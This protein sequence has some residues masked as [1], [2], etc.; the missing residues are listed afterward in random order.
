MKIVIISLYARTPLEST[1]SSRHYSIADSL[2]KLGHD[3][4]I[5][6]GSFD[7]RKEIQLLNN[8]LDFDKFNC[9]R[10]KFFR[11]RLPVRKKNLWGMIKHSFD[12]FFQLKKY[13]RYIVQDKP[14]IVIGC[15][16]HAV[17]SFQ[18]SLLSKKYKITFISEV[19][20]IWPLILRVKSDFYIFHPFYW[21]LK[22]MELWTYK[23]SSAIIHIASHFKRYLRQ[24]LIKK[25]T[26]F[27][28]NGIDL[29]FTS[30]SLVYRKKR[31]DSDFVVYY[32]GSIGPLNSI[33]VM[34]KA[35]EYVNQNNNNRPITFKFIGDGSLKLHYRDLVKA[36]G[37]SN[38]FFEDAI[39][40]KGIY[41]K[42]SEASLFWANLRPSC[43]YSYGV[44]MTK[45]PD[46]M[47]VGR[48]VVL[49]ANIPYS[50]ISD[51]NCGILVKSND[52]EA[53]GDSIISYS[54]L[55]NEE[56]DEIGENG[57]KWIVDNY[58]FDKLV[59]PLNEFI[60]SIDVN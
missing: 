47:Y 1:T 7:Q 51:A 38:V 25:P 13:F 29:N 3:V 6:C 46:Y 57:K 18:S 50:P 33:D 12:I 20:D 14:D 39:P 48:P 56:L 31:T 34:I 59:L 17:C 41:D 23:N 5:Y 37:L 19:R 9:G 27:L 58:N 49:G 21:C 11:F 2:S 16:P 60:N 42:I 54:E 30:N 10:V 24:N 4:A 40:K 32:V 22:L 8:S 52:F 28:P 35:I 55:S 36:K 53:L 44:S 45:L 15:S 43:Y 26:I